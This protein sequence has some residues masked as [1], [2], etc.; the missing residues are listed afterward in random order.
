MCN[1]ASNIH[2]LFHHSKCR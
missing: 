2:S 1:Y